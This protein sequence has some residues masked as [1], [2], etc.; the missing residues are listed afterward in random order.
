MS[1]QKLDKEL[2]LKIVKAGEKAAKEL[3][4]VPSK[5]PHK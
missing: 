1:K 3:G 5:K 2:A 4:A